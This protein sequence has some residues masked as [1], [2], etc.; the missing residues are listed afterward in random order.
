M[1]EIVSVSNRYIS[2]SVTSAGLVEP[3][4]GS[5]DIRE[6]LPF[7]DQLTQPFSFLRLGQGLEVVESYQGCDRSAPRVMTIL[8]P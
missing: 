5:G 4:D 1:L 6:I 7:A 8:V 3:F 2:I